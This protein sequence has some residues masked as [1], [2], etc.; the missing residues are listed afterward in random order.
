MLNCATNQD[1]NGTIFIL[2]HDLVPREDEENWLYFLRHF[3]NAGLAN[4]VTFFM[5]DRDK[6]LT[7]LWGKCSLTSLIPN[8]T[9]LVRNLLKKYGW[10]KSDILQQ[11]ARSYDAGEFQMYFDILRTEEYVEEIICWTHSADPKM[12]CR[13]LFPLPRFGITTWNPVEI[14]SEL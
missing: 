11:M 9:S 1:S 14:F 10:Q 5:S 7:M 6:G 12:R 4:S 13:Y 3:Q 2:A 8:A